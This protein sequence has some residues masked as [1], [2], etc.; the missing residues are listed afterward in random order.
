MEFVQ[1]S[2]AEQL[3][4]VGND[5]FGKKQFAEAVVAY[6]ECIAKTGETAVVLTN[7]AASQLHLEAY[8][9]AL[10]DSSKAVTLDKSYA[11]AYFRKSAAF[12]GLGNEKAAFDTWNDCAE[13]CENTAWLKKQV[14][15]SHERYQITSRTYQV[16]DAEDF[17]A[18]YTFQPDSRTRL[19]ALIHF[20][21][22]SSADERLQYFNYFLKL[23]GGQTGV[24][25]NMTDYS[26]ASMV[27]LP[28]FKYEDRPRAYIESWC[29]FFDMIPRNVIPARD[30]DGK[31]IEEVA[32]GERTVL[33]G[34]MYLSLSVAEQTK[35][36]NDLRYFVGGMN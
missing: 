6:D 17:M 21:N 8:D 16:L 31:V 2:E 33:L 26:S 9:A 24:A 29:T 3:K 25:S 34:Q 15:A 4:K 5:F 13:H 28:M 22:L 27:E 35:V 7:R 23:I 32:D 14:A 10:S 11:K 20:W 12:L 18:R 30:E 1:A 36:I 19:A